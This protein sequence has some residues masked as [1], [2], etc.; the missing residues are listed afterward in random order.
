MFK[1]SNRFKKTAITFFVLFFVIF[2]FMSNVSVGKAQILTIETESQPEIRTNILD[3]IKNLKDKIFSE[4]GTNL[5]NNVLRNTLNRLAYDSADAI[6]SGGQGQKPL[7]VTKNIGDYFEDI[8]DAAVGD[9]LDQLNHLGE[10][11]LCEPDLD[12]KA[13]IGLGLKDVKRPPEPSCKASTM[14]KSWEDEVQKFQDMNK[15]DFAQRFISYFKPESND[16]G[17]TVSLFQGMEQTE[18]AA[19][20]WQEYEAKDGKL[21]PMSA[22]GQLKSVRGQNER[23]FEEAQRRMSEN[24]T[25]CD[26]NAFVCAAQVF[27]NRL[28]IN[29]FQRAME[30][31]FSPDEQDPLSDFDPYDLTDP[32]SDPATVFHSGQVKLTQILEPRFDERADYDILSE[33]VTCPQTGIAGQEFVPSPNNCVIDDKFS[34][35]ISEQKTVGEA[36]KEGYLHKEWRFTGLDEEVPYNE[37]YNLRSILIL[38]KY[39][40]VPAAWEEAIYRAKKHQSA[41]LEDLVSCY[42]LHD[43]YNNFSPG[44]NDNEQW[45]RGL[46]DPDWVLKAPSNY[47]AKE[48]FGHIINKEITEGEKIKQG[49]DIASEIFVTRADDYCADEQSC[50]LENSDGTCEAYGYCSEEKRTWNFDQDSCQ[51]V[52]NTCQTFKNVNNGKTISYLKN[53]LDYGGCNSDSAGCRL[54]SLGGP[55]DVERDIVDWRAHND[56]YLN[57][58]VEGCAASDEG[59]DKLIR[60]TAGYGHN[61]IKNGS[62]EELNPDLSLWSCNE[63]CLDNDSYAGSNALD[64]NSATNNISVQVG[65]QAYNISGKTYTFSFYAKDC[66]Q[67]DDFGFRDAAYSTLE[68]SGNWEYYRLSH[69]YPANQYLGDTVDLQINSNSCLIDNVKLE[70]GDRGTNYSDYGDNNVVYQKMIPEY[71]WDDCYEDPYSGNLDFSLQ[72]DAPEICSNNYSRFCNA[73]EAGCMIYTNIEDRNDEVVAQTSVQDYCPSECNNYDLY[74]GAEDYFNS[75]QGAKFIPDTA[76]ACSATNAGCT[77]FTNLDVLESGGEAKEYYSSL[78]QCIKPSENDCAAFYVW[79]GSS[80]EGYQLESYS[81]KKAEN[82]NEPAVVEDDSSVCNEEIYNLPITN[83]AYNPDCY[84]FYNTEGEVSYH[85][86]SKTITCS[87]DCHPYRM[88]ERNVDESVTSSLECSNLD[89][90]DAVQW[91]SATDTCYHCKNG[92]T[93]SSEYDACVYQAIPGQGESCSQAAS[94]C[95]EYNGNSGNNVRIVKTFDFADSLQGWQGRCG[96][97]AELSTEALGRN[98]KSLWYNQGG[99]GE[100]CSEDRVE[101]ELGSYDLNRGS[102]YSLKFMAKVNTATDLDVYFKNNND[103][104]AYFEITSVEDNSSSVVLRGDNEWHQY[105]LSLESLNH[106]LSLNETLVIES[107]NSFYLDNVILREIVDRYYL[108]EDS[109]ETPSL[110]Y[111]DT[112]GDYQGAD[113]N[114]GCTGY[115]NSSGA[116]E[117]LRS[118]SR[119]C[120]ESAVG[121]QLMANTFNTKDYNET[122]YKDTDNNGVCDPSEEDC[123][124]VSADEYTFAVYNPDNACS[125]DA[126]SCQ[127]LGENVTYG[128]SSLFDDVY[129][130][131]DPDKYNS[132]LCTADTINCESYVSDTGE[133]VYFRDPGNKLCEWR[134][135]DN[136]WNWYQ[137]EV[138]RCDVNNNGAGERV[139]NICNSSSD[140][141][142]STKALEDAN[143]DD[144]CSSAEDCRINVCDLSTGTCSVG[145]NPCT[146]NSS[147]YNNNSCVDGLCAYDCVAPEEDFACPIDQFKTIGFGG[148]G[149]FVKQPTD[150]WTGLCEASASTCSEFID[151][152]S[153]HSA[154]LLYNPTFRDINKDGVVGD[155]WINDGSGP[156]QN[157]NIKANKPYVFAVNNLSSS[158]I[159]PTL[160]CPEDSR[161]L[162]ESNEFSVSKTMTL[163]AGADHRY[164][165]V[166]SSMDQ[167]CQLHRESSTYNADNEFELILKEAVIDYQLAKN[168]DTKTCNGNVDLEGGCI[169]FNNRVQDVNGSNDLIY[170]AYDSYISENKSPDDHSIYTNANTLV[171]VSPNRV[172]SKWLACQTKIVDEDG[173]VTC[174]DVADCDAL[175]ENGDCANFLKTP[176]EVRVFDEVKDKNSTGY[177][178]FKQFHISNMSELG[179]IPQS[180]YF[181]F[182]GGVNWEGEKINDSIIV[183]EPAPLEKVK[184]F[185][186]SYPAEGEAFLKTRSTAKVRSPEINLYKNQ[187][188]F[189]NYLLNTNNLSYGKEAKIT[190]Y[191]FE[192]TEDG[193]NEEVIGSWTDRTDD[194][195]ERKVYRFRLDNYNKIRIE[196]SSNDFDKNKYVYIDDVNIEPALNISRGNDDNYVSK[197]CRLYP[198]QDSLSCKSIEDNVISNGWQGYCLEKDPYH[199]DICLTWYPVDSI[200]IFNNKASGYTGKVPNYYCTQADADFIVAEKRKVDVQNIRCCDEDGCPDLFGQSRQCLSFKVAETDAG[201]DNEYKLLK[202][203]IPDLG[204][205]EC[206][207]TLTTTG[208]AYFDIYLPKNAENVEID[209]DCEHRHDDAEKDYPDNMPLKYHT[210]DF[211][212]PLSGAFTGE[213]V[214][215]FE[216]PGGIATC[217]GEPCNNIIVKYNLGWFEH[218]GDLVY[219]EDDRDRTGEEPDNDPLIKIYD[220]KD[221]YM[222]PLEEYKVRCTQFTKAVDDLGGNKAWVNR[223]V[224]QSDVTPRFLSPYHSLLNKYIYDR[225]DQ[226]FGSSI[227]SEEYFEE[228]KPIY[229]RN[230]HFSDN[231]KQEPDSYA[232]LPYGC[233]DADDSDDINTCNLLGF[234]SNNPLN[235]CIMFGADKNLSTEINE[236]QCGENSECLPYFNSLDE[237]NMAYTCSET[238]NFC[239]DQCPGEDN[240]GNENICKKVDIESESLKA[241]EEV[242]QCTKD[243]SPCF[244]DA[245]CPG[246]DNICLQQESPD[247]E[248]IPEE[249]DAVLR[250]IFLKSYAKKIYINSSWL[251]GYPYDYSFSADSEDNFTKICKDNQLDQDG[252]REETE[253]CAI[254]PIIENIGLYKEGEDV[255]V[256]F[257]GANGEHI[258]DS[259]DFYELKF[260]SIIDEEQLPLFDIFIDWGDGNKQVITDQDHRPD[261]KSPHVIKHMYAGVEGEVGRQIKIMIRD[262]WGYNKCCISDTDCDYVRPPF[263]GNTSWPTQCPIF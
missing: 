113:Y 162:N 226:P 247:I 229:F 207:A 34:N 110:C 190:I 194:N 99:G 125:A 109:W 7:F 146:D 102:A 50:I 112:L 66:A 33:L 124:S 126:K 115:N 4:V 170:S 72:E 28:A 59:C 200:S 144:T 143:I 205:S 128:Q 203:F 135:V 3:K 159:M 183:D 86:Y 29:S 100:A 1:A 52:Y 71:L 82:N 81:L 133:N 172:C 32:D 137:K 252:E 163:T 242:Y 186:A 261:P 76:D 249:G 63:S 141:I 95:R 10:M 42:D 209:N 161:Y 79:E 153:T 114:L 45:C 255:P 187:D 257:N 157:V 177:S 96:D 58:N 253:D 168:L 118:F 208:G 181:N 198:K 2:S 232:T 69:T 17:I 30:I 199:S 197:S 105:E 36:M 8:G 241:E 150:G 21:E 104:K 9:F 206:S 195:W 93:W 88:S 80:Q 158:S 94:G 136:D 53:S 49:D 83:P 142:I 217:N 54:Y 90:S 15:K 218:N 13:R 130:K 248:P 147:C 256:L 116:A 119:L 178:I 258:I 22:G 108:I 148:A 251:N 25:N 65:P 250:K 171:K 201:A 179:S 120:Q 185:S 234:C 236:S 73:D 38:K 74:I 62:F 127:R 254:A 235:T 46:I 85:L 122:V 230:Y 117:Y 202:I 41:T 60:V 220:N 223:T 18:Q 228:D 215:K 263:E 138:N 140:C 239:I 246:E 78:K 101:V 20:K 55:Y 214:E 56:I 165:I 151:P 61:F 152:V 24:M 89:E 231:L 189:I 149:N 11:N 19:I 84:Q 175:D 132:I 156:Y 169:L 262:N 43:E 48:G 134:E 173:N 51:P 184:Q 193:E 166:L 92:G 77:E 14:V 121:C 37:A 180:S 212:Y 35:A 111:Y 75:T 244:P 176:D 167:E 70:L 87:E 123:V 227:V 225:T 191:G 155:K 98:D 16:L 188:Y 160:M 219:R 23:N 259:S 39:R 237:N 27:V 57:N 107:D 106:S 245:Y 64:L 145:G 154:N 47:C 196:V 210:G 131:N 44:F 213:V 12:I 211:N 221:A 240:E 238:G 260:N 243:S 91:D 182:E 216:I 139:E 97:E 164:M 26:G 6:V 103:L 31:A 129:V 192:V 174:Y 5:L 233:K 40:I 224:D 67:G 68:S 222:Y 204:D